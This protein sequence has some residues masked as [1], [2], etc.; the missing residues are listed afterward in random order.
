[1]TERDRSVS[2]S[3]YCIVDEDVLSMEKLISVML[4]CKNDTDESIVHGDDG[5]MFVDSAG[6]SKFELHIGPVE[7]VVTDEK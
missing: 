1:M 6:E 4:G 7:T 3:R 5:L 2:T